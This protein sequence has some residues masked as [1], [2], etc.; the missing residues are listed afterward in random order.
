M[1]KEV[2]INEVP[3]TAVRFQTY[4]QRL[5]SMDHGF[6]SNFITCYG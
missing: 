2:Q 1:Q 5:T 6:V 4:K 3:I